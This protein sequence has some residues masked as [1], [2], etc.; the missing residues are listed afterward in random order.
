MIRRCSI[1][2]LCL[3]LGVI[4]APAAAATAQSVAPQLDDSI[5]YQFGE[6]LAFRASIS[7][8]QGVLRA[9]VFYRPVGAP[10]TYV[11]V[12]SPP[13]NPEA[14]DL[15]HDLMGQPMPP[16]RSI[17]YWWKVDLADGSEF[18]TP[19][20]TFTYADDR[21]NWQT[22]SSQAVHL[23]WYKGDFVQAQAALDLSLDALHD[24]QREL[25]LPDPERVEIYLYDTAEDLQSS[26]Q[27]TPGDSV[28]GQALL[29]EGIILLAAPLNAEGM[30]ELE[31]GIPHEL[32]HLLLSAR[33]GSAY[34]GLP[35]WLSEGLAILQETSPHPQYRLALDEAVRSNELLPLEGLCASFPTTGQQAVLAYAQSASLV[36]YVKD[37]Y[38]VGGISALLD[39]YQEGASCRGAVERVLRR[40]LEVLDQEWRASL[41]TQFPWPERLPGWIWP[42]AFS[43]LALLSAVGLSI[44]RRRGNAQQKG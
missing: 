33:L 9:A 27:R 5:E 29:E 8:D 42:I 11:L 34:E 36:G 40:S 35:A 32:T 31:R 3:L 38:G 28:H 6:Y 18:S 26:L 24:I 19:V 41:V 22:I 10:D 39:A 20:R 7:A 13:V 43:T 30:D 44:L 4:F 25:S 2:A 15:V 17:E 37:V 23:H 21:F 1:P 12:S 14:I 16:F